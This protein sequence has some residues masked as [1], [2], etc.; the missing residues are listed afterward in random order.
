VPVVVVVVHQHSQAPLE[1]VVLEGSRVVVVV[2][3]VHLKTGWHQA[4]AAKV[5]RG[6]LW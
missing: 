1:Q 5:A 6:S 4:Q 3:A 2:V